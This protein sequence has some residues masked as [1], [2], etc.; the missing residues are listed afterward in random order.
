[1]FASD[2]VGR[3]ISA[4]LLLVLVSFFQVSQADD[5]ISIGIGDAN[6]DIDVFRIGLQRDFSKRWL[7]D[8]SWG[9]SGFWELSVSRWDSVGDDDSINAVAFSPVFTCSP[10][11]STGFKPYIEGG[12]GVAFISD[13]ELGA[14]D[15]STGF[16]FED[17]IGVGILFG[18]QQQH[19][20]NFK[21]L[22]YSNADIEMP[23]DGIDIFMLSYGY[24]FSS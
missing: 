22:H 1:M 8:R 19:D 13:T 9:L 6:E 17:R 2:V 23:N 16:Q 24:A 3:A 5:R 4:F 7:R 18:R 15:F 10:N 21:F 14:R 20:L 11:R 12:I